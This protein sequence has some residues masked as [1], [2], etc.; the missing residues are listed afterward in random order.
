MSGPTQVHPDDED[1]VVREMT[2]ELEAVGTGSPIEL[3]AG[4]ADRVMAAIAQE[5]LPQ[6]ARAFRL[7]LAAGRLRAAASSVGDAW[8][9]AIGGFAPAAVR[10]QALALV[11]VVAIASITLAGCPLA[12][13]REVER[14]TERSTAA[15]TPGRRHQSLE[16]VTECGAP[17][18]LL[19][20]EPR[21][22]R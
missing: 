2:R 8:R 21:S 10:A 19:S 15:R 9:V 13:P 1:R 3:P 20:G 16:L 6:P 4:F 18:S 17:T 11:I 7:A 12:R 5:P 14:T 22:R